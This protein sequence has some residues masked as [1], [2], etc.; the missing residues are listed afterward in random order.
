ME[1][2]IAGLTKSGGMLGTVDLEIFYWWCTAIM[3]CIHA[4]FLAYEMGASRAKNVLASGVKNILAFAFIVPTFFFFG[5]W[6]YLAFPSGIIPGE[7][8]AAGLP[9]AAEMG[10]NLSDNASGVFWAAFVLFAATTAS[11]FSGAVIERI[12]V[13]AFVILAILLGS[14]A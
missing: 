4:G 12:R 3:I 1:S 14:V 5:W 7:S 11:I 8:G 6:I 9:W 13:S 10:P 2:Q